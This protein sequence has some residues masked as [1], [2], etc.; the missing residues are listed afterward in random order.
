M[1]T[2]YSDSDDDSTD[3]SDTL[4]V[5]FVCYED[6]ADLEIE[7][8]EDGLPVVQNHDEIVENGETYDEVRAL[9]DTE[10]NREHVTDSMIVEPG[11]YRWK[12]EYADF[13]VGDSERI[14]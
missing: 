1:P 14:S 2:D 6:S 10:Q 9:H 4:I 12:P 13:E 3:S 7:Y 5:Q 11:D 8:D